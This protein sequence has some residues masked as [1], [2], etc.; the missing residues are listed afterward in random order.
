MFLG[1]KNQ[2]CE[3]GYTTKCN[4]QIQCDSYHI[5]NGIFHRTR[6]KNLTIH[7]ETQKSPNS[8]SSLEEE[9]WSWRNQPS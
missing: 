2:H 8:Q 5:T 1:R 9:E 7:M 4:L 3:N 6:T